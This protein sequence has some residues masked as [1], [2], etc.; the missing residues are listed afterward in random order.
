MTNQSCFSLESSDVAIYSSVSHGVLVRFAMGSNLS[1]NGG[2]LLDVLGEGRRAFSGFNDVRDT[3]VRH[4]RDDFR[5]I[6]RDRLGRGISFLIGRK[7]PIRDGSVS[8]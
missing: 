4:D 8:L 3:L 6:T 2:E 5:A 1:V 7:E